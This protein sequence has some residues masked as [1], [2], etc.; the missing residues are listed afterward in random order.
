MIKCWLFKLFIFTSPLQLVKPYKL[1]TRN[2]VV[3]YRNGQRN[4]PNLH[5]AK[6]N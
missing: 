3:V 5:P 2:S 6:Q 1:E 4:S